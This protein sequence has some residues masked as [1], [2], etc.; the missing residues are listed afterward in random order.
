MLLPP[1]Q[2][3]DQVG[4]E[5]PALVVALALLLAE[6]AVVDHAGELDDALQLHLAPAAAHVRGAERGHEVARLRAQAL[7]SLGDRAELLAD[8]RDRAQALLLER[9]R[10]LLEAVSVSLIGASFAS[11]SSSSDDWLFASASPVAALSRSSH[12]AVALLGRR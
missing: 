7:L 11:A 12:C 6:V 4:A 8:R 10:L 9:L 3:D 1:G 5:Q 2:L